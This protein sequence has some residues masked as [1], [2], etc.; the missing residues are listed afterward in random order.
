MVSFYLLFFNIIFFYSFFGVES[1]IPEGRNAHSSITVNNQLY[2]FGGVNDDDVVLSEVFYLDLSKPFDTNAPSWIDISASSAIPVR[3]AWPAV[4]LINNNNDPT[5][6]LIGGIMRDQNNQNLLT[7]LVY[8]F[9]PKSGQWNSP[10]IKGTEPIRRREN[11]AVA[12]EAGNIYMFGGLADRFVGSSTFQV[13]N[14]MVILNVNDL[15]W[16]DGSTIDAPVQRSDYTATLL[17]DGRIVYIGGIERTADNISRVVD[18]NQINIY[19]TK[20][21]SWSVMVCIY[22]NNSFV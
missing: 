6:Y 13:F 8:Q 19:D 15:T 3:S 18:I 11:K 7:T 17:P 4:T 22:N 10:V 1:L 21:T 2:F 9:N 14:D 12:D 5:I 20:S 16:S